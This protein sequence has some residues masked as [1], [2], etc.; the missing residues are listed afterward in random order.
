LLLVLEDGVDSLS[1]LGLGELAHDLFL[2]IYL[3]VIF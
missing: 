2:R 3:I 1:D